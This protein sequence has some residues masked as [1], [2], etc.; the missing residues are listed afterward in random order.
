MIEASDAELVSRAIAADDRPAFGELV[1]RHQGL[2]RHLLCR[3]AAGDAALAD[4]LA[5]EAFLRAYLALGSFRSEARFSTW[6]CR[7]AVNLF[8]ADRRRPARPVPDPVPGARPAE[9]GIL[10]ADVERAM[11]RLEEPERAAISLSCVAGLSHSEIAEVMGLPLGTVKTHILRGRE[12][13][14]PL[15]EAWKDTV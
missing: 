13:L 7:I 14:R 10:A 6:L 9:R 15:L 4:D 8:L 2:V 5:Q 12:R 3:M 1:R 11:A